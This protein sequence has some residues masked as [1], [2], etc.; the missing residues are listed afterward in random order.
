MLFGA[1]CYSDLTLEILEK[2]LTAMGHFYLVQKCTHVQ[3]L[4]LMATC[5]HRHT[6][7]AVAPLSRTLVWRILPS[8]RL[9]LAA[10]LSF[11]I[12]CIDFLLPPALFGFGMVDTLLALHC[13]LQTPC[14]ETPVHSL[15]LLLKQRPLIYEGTT[16]T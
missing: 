1:Y 8:E 3:G 16:C 9:I 6:G 5:L 13:L 2:R 12:L 10:I 4:I 14:Q 15:S 7:Y 11:R